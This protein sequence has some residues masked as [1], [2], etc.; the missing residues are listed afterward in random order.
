MTT[1]PV[2]LA[3]LLPDAGVRT[4]EAE[5]VRSAGVGE[6]TVFLEIEGISG[7]GDGSC[8]VSDKLAG[9][10][11]LLDSTGR[12]RKEAGTRGAAAGISGGPAPVDCH[13]D[14]IA[15]ADFASTRVQTFSR[16]LQHLGEFQSE[17]AVMDLRFAPDGTLW[18]CAQ[19]R[20]AKEL[21]RYDIQGKLL[22]RVLPAH[23]TGEAFSDVFLCAV[24]YR[25][26]VWLAYCV[27][28]LIEVWDS[29]G[30]LLRTISVPGLPA[31]P[32]TRTVRRGLLRAPLY[33]PDGPL[34]RSIAVDPCGNLLVLGGDY[35]EHPG[36]DL[37]LVSPNR[38]DVQQLTLGRRA[39]RIW[40]NSSGDLFAVDDSKSRIDTYRLRTAAAV[41]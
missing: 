39:C 6:E 27:R 29:S 31:E 14:V 40:L 36:R 2:L 32:P 7:W 3:L 8:V 1:L 24:D 16:A 17:G 22:R 18:L 21:L 20:R 10:I 13:G 41:P 33:L 23:L 12:L 4:L 34:I 19:T 5:L 35:T 26:H 38:S 25:G 9:T 28:N 30:V 15:V 11:V 37:Y